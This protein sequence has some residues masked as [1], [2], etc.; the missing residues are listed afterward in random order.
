MRG[1]WVVAVWLGLAGFSAGAGTN[2]FWAYIGTYT[3][4]GSE[5][6]YAARFDAE[7]GELSPLKLAAKLANPCFLAVRPGGES[8]ITASDIG[9][10]GTVAAFGIDVK[11]GGLTALND[12]MCGSKGI[13]HVSYDATGKYAFAASYGSGQIFAWK[14]G[15]AGR[16]GELTARV[17]HTGKGANPSRQAG[18][19]AHQIVTDPGNK[20]VFVCD[21]GLDKVMEYALD[22]E[23]G[24]LTAAEPAFT[25]VAPGAGPRHLV[26]APGGRFAYVVNEMGSSVTAFAYAGE[27]GRLRELATYPTLPAGYPNAAANTGAEVVVHPSGKWL[28]ASNR[29]AD[30][31]AIFNV[32]AETGLLS[33]AGYEPTGGSTPRFFTLDPTGKWLFAGNQNSASLKIFAVNPETGGLTPAGPG[34]TLNAP[35]SVVFV[36]AL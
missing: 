31:I 5:G 6:I 17:Q 30:D 2:V 14:V 25:R 26:F 15:L 10:N 7:T 32:N 22:G 9:T 36:P 24:S 4:K 21:L 20:Y 29:G 35:V 13:C 3:G 8:L 23:S 12:F 28:Y 27:S 16:L 18:P 34:V 19:H 33:P 11:S 1:L